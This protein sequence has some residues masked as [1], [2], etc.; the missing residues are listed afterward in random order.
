[1]K[2]L[3]DPLEHVGRFDEL[4]R[5]LEKEQGIA[6]VTGTMESQKAHLAAGLSQDV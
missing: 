2:A 1:M 5:Q 6:V 4:K 3:L